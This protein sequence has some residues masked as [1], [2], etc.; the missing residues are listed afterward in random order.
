MKNTR[1]GIDANHYLSRL[2]GF[3]KE[4]FLDAIGGF[5][6]SLKAYIESDLQIFKEYNIT[7]VFVFSGNDT[8]D[9]YN[10]KSSRDATPAEKHR[11]NSWHK[12]SLLSDQQSPSAFPLPALDTF[13]EYHTAFR[14][15]QIFSELIDYLREKGIEFIRAPYLSWVQLSYLYETDFI[16]AVYGPTETL[17]LPSI[18]KFILGMEFQTQEFRFVDSLKV[19]KDFNIN[20]QQLLDIAVSVGCDLQ[21]VTLPLYQNY[22]VSAVFGFALDIV[23]TGGNIYASVLALNSEDVISKFQRGILSMQYMPVLKTNGRVEIHNFDESNG[24]KE[25]QPPTDL[26]DIIGQRLPHEF[27]FY[28]SIGLIQPKILE[29]IVYGSYVEKPP[30]DGGQTSQYRTLVNTTI[31]DFKNKELNLLTQNMARYYQVKK[32]TFKRYFDSEVQLENRVASPIFSRINDITVRSDIKD[33]TLNSLL[34]SLQKEGLFGKPAH[35]A[36]DEEDKLQTNYEA[37]STSLIRALHLLG[38]LK[39]KGLDFE[40]LKWTNILFKLKDLDPQ[41]QEEYLSLLI[42]L[43]SDAFELQEEFSGAN[44]PGGSKTADKENRKIINLISRL[45]IFIR[46]EHKNQSYAGPVSKGLLA[47]RSSLDLVRRNIRELLECTLVSSLSNNEIS[48]INKTREDWRS[49]VSQIPFKTTTPSTTLGIVYQTFLD[50]HFSGIEL[51]QSKKST[52]EY[53]DNQGNTLANL[54]KDFDNGFKF[55]IEATKLAKLLRDDELISEKA[56]DTFV[57]A[58]KLAN[59]V[60]SL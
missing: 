29:S 7:P 24:S 12:Y 35:K 44:L 30:L 15:D 48:K 14:P 4:Q 16:D 52:L 32:I 28:E 9:Q 6:Y 37:I 47:F 43:K 46:T 51:G 25:A 19:L 26:H 3:K 50:Q 21:P 34:N 27:Y 58:Q 31:N 49:L 17:L 60:L 40:P 1:L 45:G 53:F 18:D 20:Q 2:V 59:R 55:V 36:T 57:K 13:K 42:F 39:V 10:F 33:F 22:P 5:P 8:L 38:F 11:N 41:F 56:Y 54:P 23:N